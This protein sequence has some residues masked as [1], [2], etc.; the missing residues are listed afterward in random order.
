MELR[1]IFLGGA[2][3][4]AVCSLSLGGATARERRLKIGLLGLGLVL[5]LISAVL[6]LTRL[7]EGM[8]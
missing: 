5:F 6:V 7:D 2:I 3:L 1:W 4:C 8:M